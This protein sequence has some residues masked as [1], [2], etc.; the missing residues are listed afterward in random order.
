MSCTANV[1]QRVLS[2][3]RANW[4]FEQEDFT[5]EA[6]DA[7]GCVTKYFHPGPDGLSK[8]ES[9]WWVYPTLWCIGVSLRLLRRLHYLYI[10][11]HLKHF[12]LSIIHYTL[13]IILCTRQS[14][15]HEPLGRREQRAERGMTKSP[16][17]SKNRN[18]YIS[19]WWLF[20]YFLRS[21]RNLRNIY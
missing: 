3:S 12:I 19:F 15:K 11:T 20:S 4:S 21:G 17:P 8:Q 13:Y 6:C 16:F 2:I 9:A 18:N 14:I 5:C 1:T 7:D 10:K